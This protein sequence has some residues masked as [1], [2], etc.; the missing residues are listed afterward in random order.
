MMNNQEL[1]TAL[2]L[3]INLTVIILRNDGYGMIH[4]KQA[5][6]GFTDFGLVYDTPDF[7]MYAQSY[8]PKGHEWKAPTASCHCCNVAPASRAS[9]PVLSPM[10]SRRSAASRPRV[11]VVKALN[12]VLKI[13]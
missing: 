1:E 3:K 11:W 9:T 5:N 4:W 8:G 12:T 7:V 2:H 6:M 13:T 10:K